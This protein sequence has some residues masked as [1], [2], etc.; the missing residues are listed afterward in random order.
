MKRTL[1]QFDESTYRRLRDRAYRQH[2]SMAA[3]VRELVATGLDA[4]DGRTAARPRRR[5]ITRRAARSVVAR[6]PDGAT[7]STE[8]LPLGSRVRRSRYNE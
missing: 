5:K 1:V 3:L 7:A 6:S 8:G 2:R 4:A